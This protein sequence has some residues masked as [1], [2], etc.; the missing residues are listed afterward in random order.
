M[1]PK[2]RARKGGAGGASG[3]GGG[4]GRGN[5]AAV[6]AEEATAL[7]QRAPRDVLESFLAEVGVGCLA[8]T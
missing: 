8:V 2:K 7:I 4:G 3:S 6:E 5:P 1:P